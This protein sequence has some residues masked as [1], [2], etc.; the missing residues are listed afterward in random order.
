M[1]CICSVASDFLIKKFSFINSGQLIFCKYF[2][3]M[4]ILMVYAMIFRKKLGFNIVYLFMGIVLYISINFWVEGVKNTPLP[5]ACVV[6]FLGP[7]ISYFSYGMIND[8]KRGYPFVFFICYCGS[9]IT[10][11]PYFG[12]IFGVS[13]LIISVIGFSC[14]DIL[15]KIASKLGSVLEI[16]FWTSLFVSTA[17]LFNDPIDFDNLR[18]YA[19]LLP[20]LSFLN[21]MVLGCIIRAYS[22]SCLKDVQPLK[23]VEVVFAGLL[24]N[25]SMKDGSQYVISN[26]IGFL[27][28]LIANVF[29]YWRN[30]YKE[31]RI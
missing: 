16:V 6:S 4:V 29:C 11:L 14:L 3:S 12:N 15:N 18:E 22:L 2:G 9:V 24:E 10:I 30:K 23:Y 1:S 25:F 17:S 26:I 20:V 31:K 13:Y 28:I 8:K 7:I 27:F 5:I 19:Y 21:V